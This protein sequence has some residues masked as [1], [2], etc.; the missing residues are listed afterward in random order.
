[1][2][3]KTW[4]VHGERTMFKEFA[5]AVWEWMQVCAPIIFIVLFF[6]AVGFTVYRVSK[7][8]CEHAKAFSKH[9]VR[10]DQ[11]GC[12]IKDEDGHWRKLPDPAHYLE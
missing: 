9:E 6:C 4:A 5:N 1:M 8:G 2:R 12:Y 11:F 10:G 7:A 3:A